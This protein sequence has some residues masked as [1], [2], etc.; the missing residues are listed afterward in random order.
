[1]S[2]MSK[3]TRPSHYGKLRFAVVF[4]GLIGLF[5]GVAYATHSGPFHKA[6]SQSAA[7]SHRNIT[8]NPSP[9]NNNPADKSNASPG[10]TGDKESNQIPVNTSL[11]A[12]ITELGEA[13]NTIHFA[14]SIQN[15]SAG[16]TCVVTFSNPNDRP[17][18]K[19]FTPVSSANSAVCGP[20]NISAFE[21]SYLGQWS[22]E[23]HYYIN[24]QQATANS[25]IT[26][27]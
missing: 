22:V 7:D 20:V 27:K 3:K 12:A 14:A 26:I 16:G 9:K 13:D 17:V 6:N 11:N 24:G 15:A 10:P 1:M 5:F 8:A 4:F 21:F 2:A 23:F 25:T 19:Q 18:T